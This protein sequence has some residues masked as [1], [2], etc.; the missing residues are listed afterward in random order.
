MKNMATQK[1]RTGYQ[2]D[3][4][5]NIGIWPRVRFRY[6]VRHQWREPSG[7]F[8]TEWQLCRPRRWWS[9][10]TRPVGILFILFAIL[11]PLFLI[12]Q[13]WLRLGLAFLIGDIGVAAIG[14]ELMMAGQH[15]WLS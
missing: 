13:G 9:H 15:R 4:S 7:T 11:W 8:V 3:V 6:E 1:L 10:I 2:P 14:L 5:W 12:A